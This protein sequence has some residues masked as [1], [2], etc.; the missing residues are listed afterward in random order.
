M[1]LFYPGFRFGDPRILYRCC[2]FLVIYY[3]IFSR[4]I[5]FIEHIKAEGFA[6]G[7]ERQVGSAV[8]FLSRDVDGD[9]CFF[10]VFYDVHG[11]AVEGEFYFFLAGGYCDWGFVVDVFYG[12]AHFFADEADGEH[13]AA[14]NFEG[15]CAGV[16]DGG[17]FAVLDGGGFSY[18]HGDVGG[19]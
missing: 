16:V 7:S 14:V 3:Y 4:A 13:G 19:F 12:S 2:H 11:F 9:L 8:S 5:F 1:V 15:F 18:A 10:A 17:H 6:D